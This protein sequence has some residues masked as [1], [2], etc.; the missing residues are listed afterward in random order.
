LERRVFGVTKKKQ[1]EILRRKRGDLRES[2][3]T[4]VLR[5]KKNKR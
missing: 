3:R 4:I 2:G 5:V 1:K